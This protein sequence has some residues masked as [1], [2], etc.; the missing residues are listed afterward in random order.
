MARSRA[1]FST[2]TDQPPIT[3]KLEALTLLRGDFN[4]QTE[5]SIKK[6]LSAYGP[7]Y[8]DILS[9]RGYGGGLSGG[10]RR[11]IA[12]ELF[13]ELLNSGYI[14]EVRSD[15]TRTFEITDRG[16]IGWDMLRMEKHAVQQQE[17]A[18]NA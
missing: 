4:D 15:G 6:P 7:P 3:D 18:E 16:H 5:R 12:H 8:I 1:P 10:R 11:R 17:T 9:F 2:D 13:D 14:R